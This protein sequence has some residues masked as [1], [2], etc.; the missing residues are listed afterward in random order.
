MDSGCLK[1]VSS[2]APKK[3]RIRGHPNLTVT[4]PC[5]TSW[6]LVMNEI[7]LSPNW[8][9]RV[10]AFRRD[11]SPSCRAAVHATVR[12]HLPMP[13]SIPHGL[14]RDHI[15]AALAELDAGMDHPLGMIV[16][17]VA[18]CIE[19]AFTEYSARCDITCFRPKTSASSSPEP[20]LA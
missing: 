4:Y 10:S 18:T 2:I 11:V 12:Y 13:Q 1:S 17:P 14:T 16:S 9:A 15:L 7:P 20:R 8:V 19:M 3:I 6:T 5:I